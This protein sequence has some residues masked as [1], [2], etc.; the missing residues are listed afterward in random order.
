MCLQ[1]D[2]INGGIVEIDSELS[3]TTLDRQQLS[4]HHN[5]VKRLNKFEEHNQKVQRGSN[6]EFTVNTGRVK[7]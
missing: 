7:Y 6:N 1:K 5:I 4:S 2:E 3:I